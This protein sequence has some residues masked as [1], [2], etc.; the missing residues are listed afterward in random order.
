MNKMQLKPEH[1]PILSRGDIIEYGGTSIYTVV[2]KDPTERLSLRLA[3]GG[4]GND[5]DDREIGGISPG[6]LRFAKLINRF[7]HI[8]KKKKKKTSPTRVNMPT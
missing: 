1:Y 7:K 8:N 4:G 6:E 5:L 2:R 3:T